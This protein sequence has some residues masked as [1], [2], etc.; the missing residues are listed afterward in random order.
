MLFSSRLY[1]QG[2]WLTCLQC[3]TWSDCF[4]FEFFHK[5]RWS[6]DWS[7]VWWSWPFRSPSTVPACCRSPFAGEVDQ[8]KHRI[9]NKTEGL[10]QLYKTSE[11]VN[12]WEMW[13]IASEECFLWPLGQDSSRTELWPVSWELLLMSLKLLFFFPICLKLT[14]NVFK[15]CVW[16]S[17]RARAGRKKCPLRKPDASYPCSVQQETACVSHV[18]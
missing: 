8:N 10:W 11:L 3:S 17:W 2:L 13:Q 16:E 18:S 6:R 14:L 9:G 1:E 12:S 7:F 4:T 5:V 15:A